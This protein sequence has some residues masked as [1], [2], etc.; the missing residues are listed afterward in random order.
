MF[1][2]EGAIMSKCPECSS[3]RS[4]CKTIFNPYKPWTCPACGQ[5]VAYSRLGVF[6]S[7]VLPL[8]LFACAVAVLG[9]AFWFLAL[10]AYILG[11]VLI[12]KFAPIQDTVEIRQG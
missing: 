2:A 1:P 6:F 8:T 11:G 12:Y 9:P 10:P 4:L 7:Q 5:S 3:S